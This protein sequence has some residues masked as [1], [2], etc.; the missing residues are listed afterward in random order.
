MFS[1]LRTER[2]GTLF[3]VFTMVAVLSGFALRPPHEVVAATIRVPG[4]HRTIQS[5]IDAAHP[6]DTVLVL[7]GVYKER[8]RL[9]PRITLRSKGDDTK[10]KLGLKRAEATII[11]G[12]GK[13]DRPGVAMAEGATLDGFTVTNI[14][15]YDDA[16]WKKH[17]ATHGER[18][19]HAHIGRPGTP[20]IGVAGVNCT[21]VN[22][23]VHHNGSTGIA[24]RGVKERRCSPRLFRNVSYRNMGGGIGSM[25]GST[26]IIEQ[27]I[28]FQNF[29]AGIGQNHADPIIIGNRCY[30]NIRAG[31]G[32]SEGSKPIVRRNKCYRNRRA[33]IGIRTGAETAPVVEDNDCY[34]N[35]MAGIG[36]RD[37]ARP[38][39]RNNRCYR[40][41]LAG[42]GT[43][44]RAQAVIVGNDCRDNKRSGIG[45]R[46]GAKAKILGNKCIDNKL[47][48]IGIRGKAD[49][50]IARNELQRTGGMPPMIAVRDGSTAVV[51]GNIIRGGGVAGLLVQGTAR[52][53]GND[54]VGNG[55]R[56]GPGPPNFAVW[57]RSGS[58]VLVSGNHISGWRH[59]LDASGARKIRV[60]E[61]TASGFLG[62]AFVVTGTSTPAHLFGN[63]ALSGNPKDKVIA[64]TG[65]RGVIAENQRKQ[66]SKSRSG[67][68]IRSKP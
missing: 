8:L 47:V 59:A 3:P 26:A 23:I 40:N 29:Y 57:V 41:M 7:P 17:H 27:N 67:Q 10:G 13:G 4:G 52:I 62:T 65:P 31:I 45:V 30:Q 60:I 58:D 64:V 49:A 19:S 20:G 42:I 43:R 54:F 14:G 53:T 16:R 37:D 63:V 24:V 36:S 66:P 5:A 12:A 32:I 35:D 11:D 22:N 33:G 21:V 56:R 28:C 18:Q 48:A 38:I 55:P 61:N 2:C 15:R 25:Q 39:I 34:G 68:S 6:G 46:D 50:Y 51:T 9:K 1:T 44:N